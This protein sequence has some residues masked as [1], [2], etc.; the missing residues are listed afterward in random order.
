MSETDIYKS[1]LSHKQEIPAC[2]TPEIRY[3]ISIKTLVSQL[4]F[5]V[6]TPCRFV[7]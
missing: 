3:F 1:R 4:V 6:F 2:S 7:Y 5:S